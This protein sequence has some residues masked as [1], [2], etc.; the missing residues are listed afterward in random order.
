MST[1][2][3]TDD[4]QGAGAKEWIPALCPDWPL[5]GSHPTLVAMLLGYVAI[6]LAMEWSSPTHHLNATNQIFRLAEIVEKMSL[7]P[8]CAWSIIA[9]A[10]LTWT[11]HLCGFANVSLE[12]W[13]T[14]TAY[15]ARMKQR[16][17]VQSAM[18]KEGALL[19]AP[20]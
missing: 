18:A 1:R 10:Y 20:A 12:Q 13:P 16:P 6:L 15:L 14:L 19:Q 2:M 17:S 8:Y 3:V 11:L 9:D 5:F 7:L 4:H